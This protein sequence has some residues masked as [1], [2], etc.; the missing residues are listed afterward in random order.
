MN[1][2]KAY[3][4]PCIEVSYIQLEHGI[5]AGSYNVTPVSSGQFITDEY[6]QMEEDVELIW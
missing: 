5:A 1:N 4:P 6:E 3:I 2:K